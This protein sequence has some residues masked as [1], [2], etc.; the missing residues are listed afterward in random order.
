MKAFAASWIPMAP[1]TEM[2]QFLFLIIKGKYREYK[3]RRKKR[4]NLHSW[5]P[6]QIYLKGYVLG[7]SPLIA[8]IVDEAAD[9][10]AAKAEAI[11]SEAASA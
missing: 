9:A 4:V 7:K 5:E 2:S 3:L 1:D 8:W 6:L 11:L 10:K